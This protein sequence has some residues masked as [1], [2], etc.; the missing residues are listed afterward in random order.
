MQLALVRRLQLEVEAVVHSRR[1]DGLQKLGEPAKA[2]EG[3]SHNAVASRHGYRCCGQPRRG[4]VAR[5][6][7]DLETH[8]HIQTMLDKQSSRRELTRWAA[9]DR[10]SADKAGTI[11]N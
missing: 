10:C 9:S 5:D 11:S 2:N 4:V 3:A 6:P 1:R 7:W 8:V